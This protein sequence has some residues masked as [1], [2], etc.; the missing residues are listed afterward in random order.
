MQATIIPAAP[1]VANLFDSCLHFSKKFLYLKMLFNWKIWYIFCYLVTI[2]GVMQG[3]VCVG[4]IFTNQEFWWHP[5]MW[6]FLPFSLSIK[7]PI[8][9][10]AKLVSVN[11]SYTILQYAGS[12]KLI[13]FLV[14]DLF[15][16]QGVCTG[17]QWQNNQIPCQ[18]KLP[19]R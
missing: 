19:L 15:A 7:N 8:Q 1:H 11:T 16:L 10:L 6:W 3:V 5:N 17:V 12:L 18:A 4:V 9:N 14:G 2:P 13:L